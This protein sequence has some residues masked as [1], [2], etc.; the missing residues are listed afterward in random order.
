MSTF[1]TVDDLSLLQ[2]IKDA[3]SRV[4]LLCPK[5]IRSQLTRDLDRFN[6]LDSVEFF[7]PA[8][9]FQSLDERD[10]VIIDEL[11]PGQRKHICETVLHHTNLIDLNP[12]KLKLKVKNP[13]CSQ[14]LL[15]AVSLLREIEFYSDGVVR[16]I[17]SEKRIEEFLLRVDKVIKVDK[18]AGIQR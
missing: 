4:I 8:T 2:K 5:A 10:L 12:D 16:L 3:P 9:K 14:F 17:P 15:E 13:S 7:H 6:L 11:Y 1:N 18:N